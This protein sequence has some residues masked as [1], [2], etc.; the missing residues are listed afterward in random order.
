MRH[1][2]TLPSILAGYQRI[3]KAPFFFLALE[4][5]IRGNGIRLDVVRNLTVHDIRSSQPVLV[6]CTF[7]NE[8]VCYEDHRAHCKQREIAMKEGKKD[9][10]E[11]SSQYRIQIHNHKTG[12]VSGIELVWSDTFYQIVINWIST[13]GLNKS[14]KPFLL[15]AEWRKLSSLLRKLVDPEIFAL[16]KGNLG[17]KDFRRLAVKKI[18][19]SGKEVEIKLRTIGELFSSSKIKPAAKP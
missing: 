1:F 6:R 3:N 11:K 9:T 12:N 5:F 10:A 19:E 2:F 13:F 8:M 16:T 4:I 17:L 7:C 18:L 14:D 15:H